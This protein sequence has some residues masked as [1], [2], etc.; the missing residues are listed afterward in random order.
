MQRL[1]VALA[2]LVILATIM[3]VILST[4]TLSLGG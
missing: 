1:I 4:L 2:V 3:S